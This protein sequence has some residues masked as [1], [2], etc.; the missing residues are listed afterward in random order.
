[1]ILYDLLPEI[2][3]QAYNRIHGLEEPAKES[4]SR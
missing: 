1:M 2:A 3:V 4:T